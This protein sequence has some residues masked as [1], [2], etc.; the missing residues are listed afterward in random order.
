MTPNYQ[1]PLA[2]VDGTGSGAVLPGVERQAIL[3]LFGVHRRYGALNALNDITLDIFPNEFVFITG[4]SG[5]GKSTLLKLLY[6]GEPASEGQ[7][8]VDGLNLARISRKGIPELR[9]RFGIIFQ[10]YRLIP[11]RSVFANVSLVLE[12]MGQKEPLIRKKVHSVL[13]T[14]GLEDRG[15]ALP[16]TL[17]GGEQQRVAVARAIVGNPKILLADEPTGSLDP[18]AAAVIMALLQRYHQRGA[19]VV[20]ATHDHETIRRTPGRVIQ[21]ERGRLLSQPAAEAP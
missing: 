1:T 16:P 9:R 20:V 14:V 12:A 21:L 7:I 18:S 17:S 8:L 13:R 6:L 15:G 3:R 4:P 10:N 11:T 5:A 2:A 19:T